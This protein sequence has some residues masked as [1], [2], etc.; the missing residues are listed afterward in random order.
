MKYQRQSLMSAAIIASTVGVLLTVP[1]AMS[2]QS[3]VQGSRLVAML[4]DAETATGLLASGRLFYN[5]DAEKKSWG[6]Y[7]GQSLRLSERGEFRAAVR[8]ASKA[9]FL[10]QDSSNAEALAY[11]TRDLAYAYSLAGDLD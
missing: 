7:C 9:L 5:A 10:G 3:P 11:A 8:E 2:Q 1:A 6:Q 4:R